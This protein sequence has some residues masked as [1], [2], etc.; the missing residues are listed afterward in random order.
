MHTTLVL[1]ACEH[2]H[3]STK[4]LRMYVRTCRPRCERSSQSVRA[5]LHLS[6]DE[7]GIMSLCAHGRSVLVVDVLK[8][9]SASAWRS[10]LQVELFKFSV[11]TIRVPPSLASVFVFCARGQEGV[12]RCNVL[13]VPPT[14]CCPFNA[15]RGCM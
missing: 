10:T 5:P 15:N 12:R 7:E 2:E 6:G 13:S 11:S 14:N 8:E 1:P 3:Q 9:L 4:V